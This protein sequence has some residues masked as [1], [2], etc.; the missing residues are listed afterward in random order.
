MSRIQI[1]KF[2]P[3]FS[4]IGILLALTIIALL[5][6]LLLKAHFNKPAVDKQTQG[7]LS[8]QNIDSSTY[9]TTLKDTRR[10]VK[11]INR[12]LRDQQKQME[13]LK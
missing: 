6:F 8:E 11:D 9:Q 2:T 4:L 13:N 3:G 7:F 1:H 12:Q 5:Y 10:K